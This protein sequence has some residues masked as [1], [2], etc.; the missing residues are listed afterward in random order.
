MVRGCTDLFFEAIWEMHQGH[1]KS[2]SKAAFNFLLT[3]KDSNL[4]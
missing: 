1:E 4:K 2:R 3:H